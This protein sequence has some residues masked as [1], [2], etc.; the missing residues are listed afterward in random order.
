MLNAQYE[1]SKTKCTNNHVVIF[2]ECYRAIDRLAQMF[3]SLYHRLFFNFPPEQP[4]LPLDRLSERPSRIPELTSSCIPVPKVATATFVLFNKVLL[5]RL[6]DYIS[7]TQ[8]RIHSFEWNL[9]EYAV[10]NN[11]SSLSNSSDNLGRQLRKLVVVSVIGYNS[12]PS[13]TSDSIAAQLL[14]FWS[15]LM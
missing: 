13:L 2:A 6:V 12:S 7:R 3:C 14:D 15:S 8:R 4:H 5:D 9:V 10:H 1:L 11:S